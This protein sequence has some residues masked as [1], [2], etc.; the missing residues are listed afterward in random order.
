M[1]PDNAP[2]GERVLKDIDALPDDPAALKR[3]LRWLA[4]RNLERSLRVAVL[5]AEL[6]ARGGRIP[7]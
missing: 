7:S 2:F 1:T 4:A 3:V 5:E 6:E